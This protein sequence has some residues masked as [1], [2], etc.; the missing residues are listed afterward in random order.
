[1]FYTKKIWFLGF[2]VEIFV[3]G[4]QLD[5]CPWLSPCSNGFQLP[6]GGHS[7]HKKQKWFG[8]RIYPN[9][10]QPCWLPQSFHVQL[11]NFVTTTHSADIRPENGEEEGWVKTRG[12]VPGM[13]RAHVTSELVPVC[14]V[15]LCGAICQVTFSVMKSTGD[16]YF[17]E[18]RNLAI[19]VQILST[20][21]IIIR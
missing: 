6:T 21:L 11:G 10:P 17:T 3:I 13:I 7:K 18:V 2:L 15:G 4:L 8:Q 19:L 20:M 5:M 16:E 14:S 12:H 9:Y 1:M